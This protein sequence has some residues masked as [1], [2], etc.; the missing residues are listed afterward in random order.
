MGADAETH[1]KLELKAL[2][3]EVSFQSLPLRVWGAL[4]KRGRKNWRILPV[5]WRT[6]GEHD[7]QNQLSRV[8][9]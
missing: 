7:P 3:L 8:G 2:Y 1:T 4:R 6:P 5:R 9:S